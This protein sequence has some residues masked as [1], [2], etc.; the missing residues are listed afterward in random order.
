MNHSIRLTDREARLL[1]KLITNLTQTDQNDEFDEIVP[2][3]NEE[4][5]K[6][7]AEFQHV[8]VS[9]EVDALAQERFRQFRELYIAIN[10][11]NKRFVDRVNDDD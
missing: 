6:I 2:V 3:S 5:E 7:E 8:E 10:K 4:L 11:P 9:A 1:F